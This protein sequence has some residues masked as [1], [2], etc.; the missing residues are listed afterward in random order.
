MVISS[1]GTSLDSPFAVAFDNSDNLWVNSPVS[2]MI[3]MFTPG[4]LAASGS[5][6]PTVAIAGNVTDIG[7]LAFNPPPA[8][9]PI[10][11]P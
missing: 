9:L 5:P 8:D 4:Q 11:T 3:E 7:G 10:N 6:T 1:N 2:E